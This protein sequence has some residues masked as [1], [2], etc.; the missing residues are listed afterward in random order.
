MRDFLNMGLEIKTEEDGLA[1]IVETK[2]DKDFSDILDKE[3]KKEIKEHINK[4]YE[5]VNDAI[6]GRIKEIT[7][8]TIKEMIKETDK[9]EEEKES[10]DDYMD[11]LLKMS[12]EEL[13][14]ERERLYNNLKDEDKRK[15]D[16]LRKRIDEKKTIKE[17]LDV[18]F[19]EMIKDIEENL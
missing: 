8:D 7:N 13:D 17:K 19:E 16:D 14:K 9:E 6:K 3:Q 1:V 10:F 18:L 15:M 11:R 12:K 4:I 5:M 2:I